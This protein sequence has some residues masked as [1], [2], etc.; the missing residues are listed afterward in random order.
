M[1][2][3]QYDLSV[4]TVVLN[5]VSGLEK[6]I[7]TVQ[8]QQSLNIEHIIVDGG[9]TDG[10]ATLAAR[11]SSI[12]VPSRE[13][14]GIYPAMQRGATAATGKYLLFC[15]AGDFI[16]GKEYVSRA[17]KQLEESNSQWGFGPIIELTQRNTFAWVPANSKAHPFSIIARKDFVPFPSFIVNR[18]QFEKIGGFSDKYKIAGDFELICK[19]ASASRPTIFTEPIALFSAG[20]VSYTKADLAW[21]EEIFIRRDILNLGPFQI[22][23]EEVRFRLR[24]AKWKFGKFLDTLENKFTKSSTSWRDKRAQ[25]VPAK[26][27]FELD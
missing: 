11:H 20:G 10:S 6:T 27:L 8:S 19:I 22:L 16:F 12:A 26:Y 1:A 25:K 5:D 24:A 18:K 21:K 9:S 4:V 17:V 7:R 3:V 15:N 2:Q 14:G 13:D 23:N